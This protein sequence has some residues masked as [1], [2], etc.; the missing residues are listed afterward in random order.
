MEIKTPSSKPNPFSSLEQKL[1]FN[2]KKEIADEL[3]KM[4][5]EAYDVLSDP[6]KVTNTQ[7]DTAWMKLL[8]SRI[9]GE[10]IHVTQ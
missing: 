6:A 8:D 10:Y 3:F 9:R 7:A 1:G 5:G 2:A 4:I